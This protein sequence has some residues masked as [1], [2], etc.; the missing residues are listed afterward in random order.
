VT[1]FLLLA[2]M[3]G[4]AFILASAGMMA[5]AGPAV[6][7]ELASRINLERQSNALEPVRVDEGLSG[8]ALATSRDAMIPAPAFLTSTGGGYGTAN[9]FIIPKV[10]WALLGNDARQQIFDT[11]ENN[12]GT[13][14][15]NILNSDFRNV[16]IGVSSDGYNYYIAVEWG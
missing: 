16:G 14:R 6:A 10:S 2:G 4:I 15:A 8:L 3:A 9:V 1:L 13:F 5:E 12:D 7:G 11:M